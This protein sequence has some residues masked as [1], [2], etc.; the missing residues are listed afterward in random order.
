MKTRE[1]SP[2]R[3]GG[4]MYLDIC[5]VEELLKAL[6]KTIPDKVLKK[7][8]KLTGLIESL[9]TCVNTHREDI[10]TGR[11]IVLGRDMQEVR[12]IRDPAH[13]QPTK[14]VKPIKKAKAKTKSK[15]R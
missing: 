13:N 9:Q 4:L 11:G 8:K 3:K 14:A 1:I 2:A 10:R 6:D 15:R 5:F 12:Y 7:E